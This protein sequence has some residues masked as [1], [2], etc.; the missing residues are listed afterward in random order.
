MTCGLIERARLV[1][2]RNMGS[3]DFG[4][5]QLARLLAMSRSKLY[6]LLDGDGGVAHFINRERLARARHDLASAGETLSVHAIANQVG[7]RDHSTFSRAFRREFGCSPTQARERALAALP[8][9]A[10]PASASRDGAARRRSRGPAGEWDE[11]PRF[12]ILS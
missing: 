5:P 12:G 2:R 10:A 8:V 4:P 11:Q 9:A 6:R 1:V 3:P 7:F